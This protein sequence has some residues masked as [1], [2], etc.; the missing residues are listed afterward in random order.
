MLLGP[1]VMVVE[2][3]K[4]NTAIKISISRPC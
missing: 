2:K 3:A 4:K 1:G